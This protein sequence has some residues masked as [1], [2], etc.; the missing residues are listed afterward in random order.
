MRDSS[1]A[2]EQSEFADILASERLD[3]MD[4]KVDNVIPVSNGAGQTQLRDRLL[5]RTLVRSAD[6]IVSL[7]KL[8]TQDWEGVTLS[9]KNLFGVMP[10]AHY[11]RP[12]N[13]LHQIKITQS[14]VDITATARTNL[15]IADGVIGMEGD[16]P[17]MGTS[18]HSGVLIMGRNVPTVDATASRI[19]GIDPARID[20]LAYS[21]GWLGAI[22]EAHTEQ[23]GEGIAACVQTRNQ[24]DEPSLKALIGS[25]HPQL[26]D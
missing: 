21:A 19:M 14:I 12:K 17:I 25:D 26:S 18:Q 9:M 10:E 2:L 1:F 6:L 3:N 16:G 8:K 11:G 4:F 22:S 20:D 7:T 13:V 23:R 15:A 24:L 5:P